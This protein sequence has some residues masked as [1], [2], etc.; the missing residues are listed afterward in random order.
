MSKFSAIAK[1]VKDLL[2]KPFSFDNKVELKTKA[3]NGTTYI[4]DVS[5]AEDG[6]AAANINVQAKHGSFSVDKLTVGTEKKITGE[7]SFAEAA[8]STDL[9]FKFTDGSRASGAKT[10]ASLGATYKAGDFG[11]FTVDVDAL[12]GPNF[13]FSDLL[14]YNGV[15]AGASAKFTTNFLGGDKAPAFSFSSFLLGYQTAD[16][17]VF[18]QATGALDSVDVGLTQSASDKLTAGFLT[19]VSLKD[20]KSPKVLIG[21]QYKLDADTTVSATADAAAK[22]SFA[23]KQKLSSTS[24]VTF[25]TQVDALNLASDNHKFGVTLNLTN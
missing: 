17:T 2:Q 23:Y 9:S 5:I 14:K 16:Y 1:S 4:S 8:P 13:E 6:S 7:F 12:E 25:N 20:T 11:V 22:F 10:T 19:T 15:L 3:A 24:T 18:A 21:G